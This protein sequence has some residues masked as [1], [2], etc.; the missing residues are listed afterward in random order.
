MRG[1]FP[2]AFKTE[3][4]QCSQRTQFIVPRVRD[5][6]GSITFAQ[7]KTYGPYS[8]GPASSLLGNSGKILV[9]DTRKVP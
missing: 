7:S 5:A 1:E 3:V 9:L 2:C 4:Q 8:Y 6:E